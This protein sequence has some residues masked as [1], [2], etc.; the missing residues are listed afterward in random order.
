[1]QEKIYVHT[2][3]DVYFNGETMWFKIY[4][5]D[6]SYHQ[7]LDVSKIAYVEILS[8][9]HKPVVQVQI[10][11]DKGIGEGFL[12]IPSS[13]GSG[14]YTFRAYTNWMKNFSADCF[15]EKRITLINAYRN[16]VI[17]SN[18]S[19]RVNVQFF[20]EGGS[21]VNGLESKVAFAAS[22][23]NGNAE[24]VTGVIVNQRNDTIAR[25][26]SLRF[27]LGQFLFTPK[28]GDTYKAICFWKDG[29]IT[30]HAFPHA[31]DNGYVVGLNEVNHQLNFRVNSIGHPANEMVY[32]LVHTRQK[33]R[34]AKFGFLEYGKMNFI[35][36]KDS[37]P[38][39]VSHFTLLNANRQPICERLFFKRP[40]DTIAFHVNSTKVSVSTREKVTLSVS[41]LNSLKQTVNANA[42]ASVFLLDS[43]AQFDQSGITAYLY[44]T[45]DLKGNVDSPNYYLRGEDAD[46]EE[47]TENLVL[48]H[49]WSRFNWGDVLNN[50]SPVFQYLP[51]YNGHIVAARITTKDAGVSLGG[52]TAYLSVPAEKFQYGS[53]VADGKGLLR[54]GLRE[55]YG[56]G[57]VVVQARHEKDST[58]RIDVV[59]PFSE[60]YSKR[61]L[62]P[63]EL[64]RSWGTSLS[65]QFKAI[66][67]SRVYDDARVP[68][69]V[70]P[71]TP[72]TTAFYGEPDARYFLDDYTRFVTMEEVLREYVS[73]V[74]VRKSREGYHLRLLNQPYKVF[75][76][77]N[78]LVLIDGVPVFDMNK[79][80]AV[81]PL[82]IKKLE[83]VSR[84]FY[85][86]KDTYEGI[87]SFSTYQG[88]LGGYSLDPNALVVRYDGLQ[89][90]KEFYSPSYEDP[91]QRKN[92]LPD[93]RTTL[94]WSP[95]LQLNQSNN[96][97]QFYSSDLPGQYL[98]LIE[99][100]SP[101][102]KPGSGQFV[103]D[104]KR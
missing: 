59:S 103:I 101:D 7:F 30:T 20:P 1:M 67:V 90:N 14:N 11:L 53:A 27:G 23:I 89:I 55:F 22:G 78:P 99:G 33:L 60:N 100:L 87:L 45:S 69:F 10:G 104:V 74:M 43:L 44:L 97:L 61:L 34:V 80:M 84:K 52:T 66:D 68:A 65:N 13:A 35:I 96:T 73:Q 26:S 54:F 62:P 64:D 32:L 57:E 25:F 88:D 91:S 19:A 92:R 15:F 3:K 79:I 41:A 72:D 81:D 46:V 71:T 98:I 93:F 8:A 85:K 75:F 50:S 70:L 58:L 5:V 17:Q 29:V 38:E 83:V 76:D 77:N 36:N 47:A 42:S 51:E 12:D 2:D 82:K 49:G 37:L 21:L 31:Y 63:L 9:D 24:Q 28:G 18:D 6:A 4:D 16:S 94:F 48:T 95:N 86:G 102:G 56:A 39:G 40:A